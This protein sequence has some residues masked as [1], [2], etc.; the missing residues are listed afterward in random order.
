MRALVLHSDAHTLEALQAALQPRGWT[1]LERCPDDGDAPADLVVLGPEGDLASLVRAWRSRTLKAHTPL[2]AV[3]PAGSS[4]A[5]LVEAGCT[6][7]L[8]APVDPEELAT[9]VALA[10][11]QAPLRREARGLE[12]KLLQADRLAT[13]GTLAA[14]VAHEVN[15]PLMYVIAHLDLVARA[16]THGWL[17]PAEE[18]RERLERAVAQAREG[19]ERVRLI[20]RNLGTF[21]RGDEDHRRPVAVTEVL[22]SAVD[23]AFN[24]LRH[25]ARLVRAYEPVAPVEAS[26]SRL[27]Q[28][29]LNLLLNAAQAIPE[30]NARQHEIRVVTRSDPDGQVVVEVQDTGVG[31]KPEDLKRVFD[32]FFTTKAVGEGT[33][34]GLAICHGIVTSLGG[35]IALEN[36]PTQ[37]TIARVRLPPASRARV[38]TRPPP[39]YATGAPSLTP[40]PGARR[41]R[42]LVVDDEAAVRHALEQLLRGTHHVETAEHGRAVLVRM[43]A[44]ERFDALLVD[45]MMPEMGGIELFEALATAAPEQ[46]ERVVFLTGGAFTPRAR[47]F[48]V[49]VTNR[50]LEKPFGMA[51]L[52]GVLDALGPL[53]PS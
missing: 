8:R 30:G 17:V 31:V 24:Q 47:E 9:R 27:A 15:N 35:E 48:L 1:V 45:L 28:V 44:G 39:R 36:A 38:E 19:A 22:D 34:L 26:E 3:C 50:C 11:R 6:D 16:L 20:V 18:H 5:A 4:A 51:A 43:E 53:S 10:R 14:G 41:L 40:P 32:P 52:Q 46:R 13:V 12:D 49:S 2:L 37:G 29:F 25:R 7:Y 21:S 42:V 33:G 23:L